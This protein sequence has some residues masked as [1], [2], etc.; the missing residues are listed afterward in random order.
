VPIPNDVFELPVQT[1]ISAI[2]QAVDWTDLEALRVEEGVLVFAGEPLDNPLV[3]SGGDVGGLGIA[4]LAIGQGRAA[5]EAAHAHIQRACDPNL[6]PVEIS[7]SPKL[8]LYRDKPRVEID[9]LPPAERIASIDTPVSE[10]ISEGQF[11]SE[12]ERCLSCGSCFGCQHCWMYCNAGAFIEA[13]DQAPGNYYVLDLS[14]C[15]GC[16]KCIEVCPCGFLT[17]GPPPQS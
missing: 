14:V 12:A 11:L 15:E 5:A 2:S 4:S 3:L 13:D 16:G 8:P 6:E 7:R 1:V 17:P 10:T 9:R